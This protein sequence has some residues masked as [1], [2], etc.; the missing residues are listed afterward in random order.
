MPD[1][2]PGGLWTEAQYSKPLLTFSMHG[3]LTI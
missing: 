1:F 2:G 3:A